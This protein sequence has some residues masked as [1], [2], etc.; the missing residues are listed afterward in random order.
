VGSY[1]L[2]DGNRSL[3]ATSGGERTY[4][5]GVPFSPGLVRGPVRVVLTP[6][7]FDRIAPGDA[8]VTRSTNP[9]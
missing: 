4:W 6:G 8:L 1:L 2:A 9:G 5:R 3:E 7:Q